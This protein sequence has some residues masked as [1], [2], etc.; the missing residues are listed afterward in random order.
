MTNKYHYFSNIYRDGV[1]ACKLP[2]LDIMNP[3][4]TKFIHDVPLL[5]CGPEDWV[6]VEGSKVSIL[7]SARERHGTITCAFSGI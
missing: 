3:E 6:V 7:D 4:I 2:E 1:P 5:E